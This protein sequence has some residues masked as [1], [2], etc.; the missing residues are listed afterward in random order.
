M[1]SENTRA[2]FADLGAALCIIRSGPCVR[3]LLQEND[4]IFLEPKIQCLKIIWREGEVWEGREE[5]NLA[6]C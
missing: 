1:Y 2:H 3:N 4:E 5:V 6:K